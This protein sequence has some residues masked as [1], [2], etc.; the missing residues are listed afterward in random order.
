MEPGA[1]ELYDQA[2]LGILQHVGNVQDFLR[3]L[4]GFLYR[5][6]DFYRLLRHPS[7]RMGFPPGAA[8]A[9]VLQVFK[10]FDHMARQDDEKRKKELEEKIRKK[11]EEAK[12]LPAA[13]TEKVAVPVPVQEVEIDAAADLS[14]PQEVEKEEPPGS[15]DPEHTVTHGLEKAEAPGTVSSAA[16]GPKDPPVLPRIQEQF[17]KNPDSYNGAIRENYIWSQDYTDLEVRVPVPKHVMKG[18]QVSVALSSG[19]IRVAMVEENG[20]RVLMEGKLTH[21]INTESSLWSLEPG[22]CVLVNL[23]KVGEYWW[24]AILEG[25]EPIDIDKINK[26]RSMATVDEEE[27]AVLDRLTFDYHQKLQGKPQSHELKVHEMLKKGWDAEGSPF[28]GQRFDPAMFN[29]SPG[30][31]QF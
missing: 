29:I 12:A 4:F 31:V 30:A 17:Q 3:V 14:G 5:K 26:E 27:Q 23:S 8:Q 6:T 9:L 24:S 13:E 21:K 10:T 2:L 18:K 25:E 11:E 1:A 16:E 7:D 20:E 19:T 28:R 15:Q 22:R